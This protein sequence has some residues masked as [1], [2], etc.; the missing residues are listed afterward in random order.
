MAEHEALVRLAVERVAKSSLALPEAYEEDAWIGVRWR[1]RKR[2]FAHVVPVV[3][4]SP[5]FERAVRGPGPYV[6]LTFRSSG[7]ELDTLTR[8]G[9]PFYKLP[10]SPTAVGMYLTEATDWNEVGELVTE[11]YC[12]L[13]PKKLADRVRRPP[14]PDA[15]TPR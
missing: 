15:A 11:S 4:S 9:D 5:A 14:E 6:V 10:W 2:T 7:D 13:A 3:G 8:I 1:I 12:M